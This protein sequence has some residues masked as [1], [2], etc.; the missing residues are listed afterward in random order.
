[1][2]GQDKF[3]HWSIESLLAYQW[4]FDLYVVF[5]LGTSISPSDTHVMVVFC[6]MKL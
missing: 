3:Y 5:L 1:M 2:I 6:N 4:S